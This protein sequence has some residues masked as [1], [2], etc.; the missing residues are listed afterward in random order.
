MLS[1]SLL[2]N[3]AGNRAKRSSRS[4][5][6]FIL[7]RSLR[8]AR[9]LRHLT[10]RRFRTTVL[11]WRCSPHLPST[12]ARS[13]RSRDFSDRGSTT[14]PSPSRT[15]SVSRSKRFQSVSGQKHGR[16]TA[17]VERPQGD[18]SHQTARLAAVVHRRHKRRDRALTCRVSAW[19]FRSRSTSVTSRSRLAGG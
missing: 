19:S 10:A 18:S 14:A 7:P 17:P 4:Q 15:G 5:D 2:K 1:Y 16:R 13:H 9:A 6:S 3:H 11:R 12:S 8:Q